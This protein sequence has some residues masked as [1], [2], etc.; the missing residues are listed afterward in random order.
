[1]IVL[2]VDPSLSATGLALVDTDEMRSRVHEIKT[3]PSGPA[4]DVRSRRIALIVKSVETFVDDCLIDL[5]VIEAPSFGSRA[6]S[7][8]QH[9]RS[10][11]FFAIVSMLDARAVRVVEVSP[12]A[13]AKYATGNGAAAKM[14]VVIAT[15]ETY[16]HTLS[17]KTL[18]DNESDALAL[19]AMGARSLDASVE[20]A[21][22]ITTAQLE[23]MKRVDWHNTKGKQ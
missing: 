11:L 1:M 15:L 5:A 17:V 20:S 23:A 16:A 7:A 14:S 6:K 12:R 21:A 8:A 10:G 19:A 3:R 13:R 9:E 18:S 2:G 4:L 22:T